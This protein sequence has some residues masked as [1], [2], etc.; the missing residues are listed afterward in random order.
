MIDLLKQLCALPGVSGDELR[1]ME[2]ITERIKPYCDYK[3]DPLGNIIAHKKGA[4]P[5]KT[6]L[7]L[8]AHMDEVGMI[9]AHITAD[10]LLKPAMVGGIDP[11]V[12]AGRRVS[13]GEDGLVG[14]LG[15]VPVHL[16]SAD[17][18]EKSLK[19]DA[20]YIDIGATDK[21]EAESLVSLGDIV[22]FESH[23]TE[24]GEGKIMD[25]ALDD[26]AGCALLIK[27]I[28]SDLAYDCTFAFTVQEEVG[29]VG[30]RTA[31]YGVNPDIGIAVE[32]TT[33]ADIPTT[34]PHK[35]VCRLGGGPVISFMDGGTVYDRELY[36]CGM[37]LGK[38]LGIPCQT[39]EG[40][41]GGNESRSVQTSRDG[42]RVM[43]VSMPCRYLHSPSC[44]LDT[45]DMKQTYHLLR[46]LIEELA[47]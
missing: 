36:R 1:V 29:C 9:V 44:M 47:G 2:Y 43:A 16:L 10:G 6:K 12:V 41:Y 33:A 27:L 35:Q 42:T 24:F 39:K 4:N 7:M 22:V 17:A 19:A 11:S 30:G 37:A 31:A 38:S 15:L 8:S 40:I 21:A 28:E 25:K 3:I 46:A 13:V 18:R 34:P 20:L 14:I 26:R 32:T 45:E 5:A 23:F